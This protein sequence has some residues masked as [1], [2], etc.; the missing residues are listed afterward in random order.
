M[1][2][3]LLSLAAE[4]PA[5]LA[6][7]NNLHNED[8]ELVNVWHCGA[9]PT[10]LAGE[11]PSVIT[12]VILGENFGADRAPGAL[13]FRFREQPVTLF[14]LSHE[15]DLGFVAA[16]AHGQIEDNPAQTFGSYGWC[17][18]PGL[19]PFYRDVLLR[20]FPHHVALAGGQVAPA[21]WE[22]CGN[23]LGARVYAPGAGHSGHWTP[24]PPGSLYT[25]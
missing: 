20:F 6:D 9:F 14:R 22:A 3:H 17:R 18:L 2:M 7:W 10:S 15:P 16:V 12:N 8:D 21:L 13:A 19:I 5:G 24:E 23:Y 25:P 1:S 4:T 11:R